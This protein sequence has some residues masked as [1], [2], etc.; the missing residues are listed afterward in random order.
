MKKQQVVIKPNPNKILI[1]IPRANWNSLFSKWIKTPEGKEVELFIDIAEASGFD[2]KFQ[3]N[4]SVGMVVA[5]GENVEGVIPGDMAII[6]YI[7]TGS[8][9]YTVGFVK[10]DR[11]VCVDAITTY[12]KEDSIVNLNGMNTYKEG[13]FDEISPLYGIVRNKV[14]YSREPYVFL[15]HEDPTKMVVSENGLSRQIVE[16][17]CTRTVMA[18]NEKSIAKAGDKIRCN[19]NDITERIVN[20]CTLSVIFQQDIIAVL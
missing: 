17:F 5:V 16:E 12:H 19:S 2:R 10:G 18:S 15:F 4:V 7:V 20:N 6:D 3:Q 11:I 9:D 8:D 14:A 13:D 1:K